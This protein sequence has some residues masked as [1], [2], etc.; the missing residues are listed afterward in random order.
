M[1]PYTSISRS[2][3]TKHLSLELCGAIATLLNRAKVENILWGSSLLTAY[4]VPTIIPV[5][6]L[7]YI[8]NDRI[9]IAGI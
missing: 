7:T 5:S 3:S 1:V 9:L 8:F 4:T 6:F 2:H